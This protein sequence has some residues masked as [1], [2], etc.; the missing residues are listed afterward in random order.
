[1]NNISMKANMLNRALNRFQAIKLSMLQNI[2]RA[3]YNHL[4]A[5]ANIVVEPYSGSTY[6]SNISDIRREI[7]SLPY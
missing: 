3:K 4:V 6:I 7:Q 1:M 5:S 2:D